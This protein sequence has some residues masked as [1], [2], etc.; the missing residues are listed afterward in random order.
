MIQNH[1]PRAEVIRK[2]TRSATAC[3]HHHANDAGLPRTATRENQANTEQRYRR[4]RTGVQHGSTATDPHDGT[5]KHPASTTGSA[6]P[7]RTT[8]TAGSSGRRGNSQP[9]RNGSVAHAVPD[10]SG[11]RSRALDTAR[12]RLPVKP[13][14]RGGGGIPSYRGTSFTVSA[15]VSG[16]AGENYLYVSQE[17]RSALRAPSGA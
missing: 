2:R 12:R 7:P 15:P 16:P 4:G 10:Q 14:A 9:R 1:G 13:S 3:T 8:S 6:T 5:P 17:A 11:R